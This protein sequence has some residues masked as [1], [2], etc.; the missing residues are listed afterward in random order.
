MTALD[1]IGEG[2]D[3]DLEFFDLEGEVRPHVVSVTPSNGTSDV[4]NDVVLEFVFSEEVFANRTGVILMVNQDT[5]EGFWIKAD[6]TH[7]VQIEGN[8][9]TITPAEHLQPG[10]QYSIEGF[11]RAFLTADGGT[12]LDVGGEEASP[13]YFTVSEDAADS[14]PQYLGSAAADLLRGGS[15]DDILR[16]SRGDDILSG[17]EGNDSLYG[18]RG[19]DEL[20]GGVGADYLQGATGDDFLL[21]G[22]GDDTLGG[23]TDNDL[24]DGGT[25]ADRLIGGDGSDFLVG[26]EGNDFL[27]G[28]TGNDNLLGGADDD[29]LQGGVGYDVLEGGTGN[30]TLVGGADG[31]LFV[32][33]SD[34]GPY[35]GPY[36]DD[37]EECF[38]SGGH[39]VIADFNSEEGD[40]IQILVDDV[41]NF[42]TV[43]E[44]AEQQGRNVLFDLG[45]SGTLMVQNIQIE[46]LS[47]SDFNFGYAT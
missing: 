36:I 31:D 30:D 25:G 24:L 5:F 6:D 41:Y 34:F 14:Q 3:E 44:T 42:E 28:G 18:S 43:M 40:L 39:D 32:F 21:G 29:R 19:D 38:I 26:G 46:D 13:F 17:G 45:E 15:A 1:V 2:F 10:V 16:G 33:R 37:V 9:V 22:E 23:G 12:F 35:D 20:L 11:E 4:S 8:T 7:L 27:N 47:S